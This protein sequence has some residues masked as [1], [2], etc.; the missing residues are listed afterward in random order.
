MVFSGKKIA[1]S[2]P[3][4]VLE[5]SE[6]LREKTVKLGFIA[7]ACSIYGVDR[8]EIYRDT[9]GKGERDLILK[10]LQYIETPQYL[11]KRLFK[12][13]NSLRYAGLL[14]PLRIPSHKKKVDFESLKVG[15][16]REGVTNKDGTA[17]IGLDRDIRLTSNFK[18]GMR[19]T[20]KVL[21]KQPFVGEVISREEV[22][23]YWGYKAVACNLKDIFED[24]EF[25]LRIATSRYGSSLRSVMDRL[26]NNVKYSNSIRLIFGSPS[27]GLFEIVGPE[28][29]NVTD[30]VVNL[31]LEQHVETVR[32]EETIFA[33]LNLINNLLA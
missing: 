21:S 13:D 33:A 16:I 32:T 1:V 10:I 4:T 6:S 11:R 12:I 17:Y 20:V 22:G 5:E 8:V 23:D 15:D 30:Y 24:R 3:D 7:R 28:L 29:V 31:F 14:H 27:K 2:I 9:K 25:K 18:P 26:R 19:I